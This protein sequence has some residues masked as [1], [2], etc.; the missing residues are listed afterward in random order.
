MAAQ[1]ADGLWHWDGSE[2]W[3]SISLDHEEPAEL[4][5]SLDRLAEEQYYQ[6]G[7]ILARRRREWRTPDDLAHLVDEAHFMLQRIDTIETRRAV[8]E[9]QLNQGA[10]SIVSWL[11]G[12]AGER[13]DLRAERDRLNERLRAAAIEIGERAK[14]PTTKEADDI[15]S[16]ADSVRRLGIALSSAIAAMMS[17]GRDHFDQVKDAEAGL[18]LAEEGRLEALRTAEEDIA[19]ASAAQR[20]A[21]EAS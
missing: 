9:G 17:A 5:N 1:S 21:V 13:R 18:R 2:W 20:E 8:I 15:L 4:A 7:A 14:R 6:A 12:T 16:V 19:R 11:S 3:T 10:P